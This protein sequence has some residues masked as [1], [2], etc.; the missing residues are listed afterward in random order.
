MITSGLEGVYVVKKQ[1]EFIS[2]NHALAWMGFEKLGLLPRS[3]EVE[4]VLEGRLPLRREE[5]VVGGVGIVKEALRQLGVVPRDI[6]YPED[7]HAFLGR[8]LWRGTLA[9]LRRRAESEPPVFVKPVEQKRFVGMV[10]GQ[11]RDLIAT[12]HLPDDEAVYFSEAVEFV[13]EKRYFVL[14][15]EI[16]WMGHYTGDPLAQLDHQVVR[17]AQRAYRS[18]PAAYSLDFGLTSDGRTLLVE[19]NDA[20]ALGAYGTPPILYAQLIARRWK[21]ILG[22]TS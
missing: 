4:E 1:G 14:D 22:I 17:A 12:A 9:A 18:A 8:R 13:A 3:F 19:V 2:H 6:D 15:G 5:V 21:E 10:V 11:F 20:F 16:C 7:L